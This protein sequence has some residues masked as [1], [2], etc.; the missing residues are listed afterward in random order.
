[1]LAG[2][3]LAPAEAEAIAFMPLP[4]LPA[5]I[6]GPIFSGLEPSAAQP[7]AARNRS[8]ALAA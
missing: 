4:R 2:L 7:R 1:V 6:E 3:G 8:K 5:V